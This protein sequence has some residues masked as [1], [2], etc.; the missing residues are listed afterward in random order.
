MSW[1]TE[2][3]KRIMNLEEVDRSVAH[4]CQY[5]AQHEGHLSKTPTGFMS[6]SIEIR[7]ALSKTCKGKRGQCSRS[8]D[9]EHILCNGR[10]ARLAA[11]FPFRLCKAILSG[12]SNQLRRDGVTAPGVIG[13]HGAE[14]DRND[15]H[16]H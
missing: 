6:N 2:E 16:R 10:V 4:H 15:E 12:F 13:M 14:H 8:E 1:A 9:G 7:K 11:I 3:V 5:G